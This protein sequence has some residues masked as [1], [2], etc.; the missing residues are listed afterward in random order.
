MVLLGL[1]SYSLYLWHWLVVVFAGY[2]A[3]RRSPLVR[4]LLLVLSVLL[5]AL[6]WRHIKQ[7]FR[8]KSAILSRRTLFAAA[9]SAMAAVVIFGAS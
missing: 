4:V 6:S 1:M 7:P 9:T 2:V 3:P 8:G 5:A